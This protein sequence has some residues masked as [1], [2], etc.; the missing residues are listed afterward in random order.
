MKCSYHELIQSGVKPNWEN[1]RGANNKSGLNQLMTRLTK[2]SGHRTVPTLLNKQ[3]K[4]VEIGVEIRDREATPLQEALTRWRRS[5]S[6][7]KSRRRKGSR[8]SSC[9]SCLN[10]EL[11]A[12]YGAV[13]KLRCRGSRGRERERERLERGDLQLH[14]LHSGI[15]VTSALS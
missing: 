5:R 15:H 1:R 14:V 4:R 7:R 12:K 13:G 8:R 3:N 11:S 2:Q 6:R 9:Y 10:L